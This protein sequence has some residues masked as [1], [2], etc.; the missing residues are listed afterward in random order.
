MPLLMLEEQADDVETRLNRPAY[1]V[2]REAPE[3]VAAR[4]RTT[5]LQQE[6]E[7]VHVATT[8]RH[9]HQRLSEFV[10]RILRR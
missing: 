8:T 5:V 4:Q 3:V 10:G 1:F 7:Y 2:Q 9:V 6:T